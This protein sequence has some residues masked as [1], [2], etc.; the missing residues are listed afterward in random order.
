MV[1]NLIYIIRKENISKS[2]IINLLVNHPEIKFISLMAID[3]NAN[4]TDEKIP[5][6]IFINDI[7]LFF[8]GCAIQT[9]GSSVVLTGIATLNDAKVDMIIDKHSNWFV[10]YNFD[11]VDQLTNKPVGT[12]RIPSF[13][14]HNKKYI[15]SRS[16][17]KRSIN[18]MKCTLIDLFKKNPNYLKSINFDDIDDII[19][20]TATELEFWVK[21][22]EEYINIEDLTT[23]Q[24]LHEQYWNM[25]KGIVRTALEDSLIMMENYDLHPEM[26]HKEVGGVKSKIDSN[27]NYH[28]LEQLEIDWKYS[29]AMQTCDNL[30]IVKSIIKET[31]KRHKLDVTFLA[32]PIEKVAGNGAHL[33]FSIFFKLK[34]GNLINIFSDNDSEF[35]SPI[36]YG[37]IMGILKNYDI[38]NPFIS[39]T[40]DSLKRLKPGFEAPICTVASL[41]IS[42][43]IP[44]RN[45]SIL[46][47]L[48]RDSENNKSTRFELRSPNPKTNMY[49][50]ISAINMCI[51]DGIKYS[52]DKNE[53]YLLKE[54]SKKSGEYYGYLDESRMYRSEENIFEKYSEDDSNNIFGKAPK[55]VYENLLNIEKNDCSI[56]TQNSV[57]TT[58]IINSFKTSSLDQ[59]M[60]E[61]EHRLLPKYKKELNNLIKNIEINSKLISLNYLILNEIYFNLFI[62]SLD[63]ISL[64]SKIKNYIQNRNYEMISTL[65]IEIENII[66][67][68]I[69]LYNLC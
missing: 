28:I 55:T 39:N 20:N 14:T 19:I 52:I 49:L 53:K 21:T 40:I 27:G 30:L 4:D 60:M 2:S 45:R 56:L 50:T 64:S 67:D 42:K 9:D 62:D 35:M 1:E 68:F 63:H 5:T 8:D 12:L 32:K 38:I 33:H 11:N 46:I 34:N 43:D 16:I 22:P 25:T 13:L 6:E 24:G 66:D 47:A 37:A 3:L 44:S 58:D 23:S 65:H 41:G 10:D 51:I 31:F 54:L 59:Y 26:G 69:H 17:L 18:F 48:I 36:G 57:F 7:D 15:D 61:I 29:T